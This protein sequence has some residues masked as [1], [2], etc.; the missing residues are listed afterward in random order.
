MNL[1]QKEYEAK[2]KDSSYEE[3]IKTLKYEKMALVEVKK[4]LKKKDV[5]NFLSDEGLLPNYAFPEEGITLKAVLFRKVNEDAPEQVKK[6][7][8]KYQNKVYEYNRSAS[9]AISEFAPNNS[10]YAG[11]HQFTIDQVDMN[12]SKPELWRLCPNCAHAEPE[13]TVTNKAACPHCGS[14]MW[15]DEGQVREMLKVKMV[16]SNMDMTKSII[17][18]GNETREVRFYTKQLLVDVDEDRDIVAAY[19]MNNDEFP[20][21]YEFVK[22]ASLR[23]INFGEADI[24]K[25]EAM[26]VNGIEATRKGFHVCKYCGRIRDEEGKIQHAPY[27]KTRKNPT[28]LNTAEDECLFLYREFQTEVLRIL[29]PETTAA[30]IKVKTESFTAA[31]MLGMKEYFGNVDHLRATVSEVPVK[32]ADYRNQYLVVYD[33]VPGGTGYLKQLMQ[34]DDAL[35]EVFEKALHVLEQCKCKENSKK[36]GCY[37]CL[38]AY[39]QSRNIGD[40]SRRVAIQL[41][42]SILSGKEQIEKI[43]KLGDLPTNHLFDSEL[44]QQF[45]VALGQ[46]GNE[47]RKVEIQQTLVHEKQGYILNVATKSADGQEPIQYSWEVEPQVILDRM[48]GVSVKCKPDFVLWPNFDASDG[49]HLPVA[50]FTDGFLYH[51]D[52]AADDTLK[53]E[54]I[55]RSGNFRVWSLSYKD[56][57]EVF[58]TQDDFATNALDANSMPAGAQMYMPMVKQ[59][60]ATALEPAKTKAMELLMQYLA[61]PNAETAFQGQ[62]KAYAM[63]LIDKSKF[64]VALD[65]NRWHQKMEAIREDSH[66]HELSF[67]LEGT[68]FGFW[69]PRN[70]QSDLVC[71][72]GMDILEYQNQSEMAV[73]VAAVLEDRPDRRSEKYEM[74]W[75]GFWHFHN[76]MQFMGNFIAVSESGLQNTVYLALPIPEP[77]SALPVMTEDRA[78]DGWEA[79]LKKVAEFADDHEAAFIRTLLEKNLPVPDVI[80]DELIDGETVIDMVELGWS[81]KKIAFVLSVCEEAKTNI[82]K[83]GWTVFDE[84]AEHVENLFG[85]DEHE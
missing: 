70:E 6:G 30:G 7:K 18:D 3:E 53:R 67:N 2:P 60:A 27:C 8:S 15:A 71:M 29:I 59:S 43:D 84:Q 51:K 23:E 35:I 42:H 47:N 52:K 41:L 62:A 82:T 12:S 72:A 49:Q 4:E 68:F 26:V 16:Y 10:F 24:S 76:V 66:F 13:L 63:S 31:F 57:Q 83:A 56:V 81:T 17:D 54:A 75:N 45:I 77:E 44:E 58:R 79:V 85:G 14:P 50:V 55:H 1:L 37:H 40:I 64:K 61:L 78:G 48:Q 9:S 39:R 22:K 32:D 33:S 19:S 80:A 20:F 65:F 74:E 25:T 69:H 11:G 34:H 36:D 5:F 21:G 73:V 38:Y 28:L 46:M